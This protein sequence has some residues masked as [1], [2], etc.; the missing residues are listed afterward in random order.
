MT[1]A[2]E[3]KVGGPVD[4]TEQV[5]IS[6]TSDSEFI[7]LLR[8][9]E[10]V[11]VVTSRQMGKTSMVYRAM[12]QLA[13]EGFRFAYFDL[14]P[15][16]TEPSPQVYFQGI[17]KQLARKLSLDLDLSAFW[18]SH[19]DE[20][21]S[22]GFMD[23]FHVVLEH[24]DG[25]IVIVLD[26]ID[27]TLERD[28][29]DDLFTAIRSLYT[30]RPENPDLKRLSFC[31]VGVA[32][33]NELVKAPRT[34]PYNIGRTLWLTDFDATRDDLSPFA[35]ALHSDGGVARQIL[36]R[37]L[38]WTGG[39]PYLT[40]RLC[41]EARRQ[42][43]GTP[44]AIDALVAREFTH[45]DG[46]RHDAHFEQTLRFVNERVANSGEVIALYEEV[47]KGKAP[48]DQAANLAHAQL[49]LAGLVRR[50]GQGRLRPRNRLYEK[51]FDRAWVAASKPRKALNR[52]RRLANVAVA[53]LVLALAG[54]VFYYQNTVAPLKAQQ[55]ARQ[56]LERL[57]VTLEGD[58]RDF[59]HVGLPRESRDQVFAKALPYLE[60]LATGAE[61][62]RLSFTVEAGESIAPVPL[63]AWAGL[64]RLVIR[65]PGFND[66]APLAGMTGLR[67]LDVSHTGI[68]DLTPLAGLS[69]LE[70]LD[71]GSTGVSD[72]VPL[73]RLGGLRRL[74]LSN[75]LVADLS[76]LAG[77]RELREL[78]LSHTRV[79]D[80]TPLK[81]LA[82]LR[83]LALDGLGVAGVEAGKATVLADPPALGGQPKVGQV[84]RDCPV[85]PQMVAL[86]GGRFT[87]G[88]PPS[89]TDRDED[90][91]P[92]HEVDIRPLAV[93]RFETRFDE[94]AL[95]VADGAC[96]ALDDAGFGQGA[97]PVLRVSWEEAQ[98]YVRWLSKQSGKPYRLPSEAEWEYAARAGSTTARY[99]GD[100]PDQACGFANVADKSLFSALECSDGYRETAPVGVYRPNAFGLYDTI[101]NVWEWTGDCYDDSYRKSPRD[102]SQMTSGDSQPRVLRGGGWLNIPRFARSANR[103]WYSVGDRYYDLGFR[104]ART[105]SP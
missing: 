8:A 1:D 69:A 43:V 32:T 103:Y 72:L 33:P 37:V 48:Q 50:D 79:R 95:C 97:R 40:A 70:V 91:G 55:E 31:L 105:L 20:S 86:P 100:D 75:T 84:F 77:L 36:A 56:E 88:S 58:I 81:G 64:A 52:A 17:V 87:M 78:D 68:K 82:N 54:G 49:K 30:G 25:R 7:E 13:G 39:Q 99:W 14:S 42:G 46:L 2:I 18:A 44:E 60:T 51:L 94:W 66:L 53:A 41:E 35:A 10:Y 57:K 28:F 21:L 85:C 98:T 24:L 62:S 38:Y 59:T 76:P 12:T 4:S 3:L 90:E 29:T 11:N 45:L 15:L 101:G 73:A 71:L 89:E 93:A 47:L 16:R 83:H 23:F 19:A 74:D 67:E 104:V 61:A 65:D 80:L 96:P 102:C 26:E 63:A 34:T 9:G 92:Q 5:Y 6:R 22:L 27:S